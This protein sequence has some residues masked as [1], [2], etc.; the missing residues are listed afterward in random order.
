M[1]Y[2][3]R[4]CGNAERFVEEYVSYLEIPVHQSVRIG[5]SG[6]AIP[7]GDD[8]M[9]GVPDLVRCATCGSDEICVYGSLLLAA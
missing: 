8:P 4:Q 1:V 6:A 5:R 2:A 9:I 3:C 7:E